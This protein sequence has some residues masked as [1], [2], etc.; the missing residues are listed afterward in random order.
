MTIPEDLFIIF[1]D[2]DAGVPTERIFLFSL[3]HD[4]GKIKMKSSLSNDN[5][6]SFPIKF[7]K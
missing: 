6:Y 7:L 5:I 2:K 4:S 1:N 3:S